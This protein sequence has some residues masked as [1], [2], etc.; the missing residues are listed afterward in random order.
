MKLDMINEGRT[1]LA[2]NNR[3]DVYYNV[4]KKRL[5][6]RVKGKVVE[7][8]GIVV[9]EKVQ[10]VVSQAGRKRVLSSGH[11]NVH[12][13]VRGRILMAGPNPVSFDTLTKLLEKYQKDGWE[14]ES[15]TYNPFKHEAFVITTKPNEG[16]PVYKADAAL[17]NG[18][19]IFLMNR[20]A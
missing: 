12:A 18:N 3:A 5:S 8:P 2:N 15:A 1:L 19:E 10:L 13:Y 4:R 6:V 20:R 7:N 11:K 9:M 17:V 16:N 14:I